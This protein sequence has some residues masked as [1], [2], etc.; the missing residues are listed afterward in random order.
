MNVEQYRDYCLAKPGSTEGFP[1]NEVVLV[2]KVMG[3]MFAFMDVDKFDK[4]IMKCDPE[5]AIELRE[6]FEGVEP[7]YHTSNKH[8]NNVL[9]DGSVSDEHILEWTDHSYE[10]VV[11]GMT[12][13]LKME[14]AN[15]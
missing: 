8:W 7:G 4:I 12:K 2:F 6:Q 13:K 10:M 14:L 5:K 9:T 1:F 3:K 15:L 11:K